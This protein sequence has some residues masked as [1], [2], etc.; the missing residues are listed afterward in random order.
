MNAEQQQLCSAFP[1]W[2]TQ[3]SCSNF[4][5]SR[6]RNRR[7]SASSAWR[8]SLVK[9]CPIERGPGS[10][11]AEL[12]ISRQ[13]LPP[14]TRP[15]SLEP[16]PGQLARSSSW[17][18]PD[19]AIERMHHD[20]ACLKVFFKLIKGTPPRSAILITVVWPS[21]AVFAFI[22]F[23]SLFRQDSCPSSLL[24][25]LIVFLWCQCFVFVGYLLPNVWEKWDCDLSRRRCQ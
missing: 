9:I 5:F 21:R 23:I 6:L 17:S 25:C 16:R 4:V 7:E 19:F 3:L 15:A 13:L 14:Q 1:S 24:V 10:V 22:I 11:Q 12:V 8:A 20:Q 18:T 2:R